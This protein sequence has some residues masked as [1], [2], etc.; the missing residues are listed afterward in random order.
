MP[1]QWSNGKGKHIMSTPPPPQPRLQRPSPP[2]QKSCGQ[3]RTT[4]L[5]HTLPTK[6]PYPKLLARLDARQR[7]CCL[8]LWGRVIWHLRVITFDVSWIRL[9]RSVSVELGNV[10]WEFPGRIFHVRCR[11]W[12]DFAF[13][14]SKIYTLRPKRIFLPP[15]ILDAILSPLFA[16][17]HS[18]T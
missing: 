6:T 12:F 8:R 10:V 2:R 16:S 14:R 5:R 3:R 9:V 17:S 11:P 13:S 15:V 4:V 7:I 18:Q 1:G